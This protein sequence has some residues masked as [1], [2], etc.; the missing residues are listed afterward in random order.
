[1]ASSYTRSQSVMNPASAANVMIARTIIPKSST[2]HLLPGA[3]RVAEPPHPADERR[4]LSEPQI[5]ASQPSGKEL[6]VRPV[7]PE[8]GARGT[9]PRAGIPS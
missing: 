3:R 8:L 4:V 2:S 9:L 5:D 6:L 1:M 7:A